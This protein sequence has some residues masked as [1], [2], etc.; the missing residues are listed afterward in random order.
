MFWRM[1]MSRGRGGIN[2]TEG[3]MAMKIDAE[4]VP[5]NHFD[6]RKVFVICHALHI[7][8]DLITEDLTQSTK[9]GSGTFPDWLSY[10]YVMPAL[11]RSISNT[12]ECT[13][14]DFSLISS[15]KV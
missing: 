13:L 14:N 6:T 1:L 9:K 12:V 15:R 4:V 5:Y 8:I 7:L 3:Y 11:G 10:G 2:W